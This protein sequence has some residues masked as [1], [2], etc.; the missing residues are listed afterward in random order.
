MST[1]VL[2]NPYNQTSSPV[3]N[4]LLK[5]GG[6]CDHFR[7]PRL[8]R[9]YCLAGACEYA[10]QIAIVWRRFQGGRCPPNP[11]CHRAAAIHTPPPCP[12]LAPRLRAGQ[13]RR[14]R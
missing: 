9:R 6:P 3:D 8:I 7:V 10:G 1:P 2:V 4:S 14:R 11:L 12:T 5:C 13:N